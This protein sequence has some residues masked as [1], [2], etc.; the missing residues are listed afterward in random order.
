MKKDMMEPGGAAPAVAPRRRRKSAAT[1]PGPKRED[2]F[3]YPSGVAEDES[4]TAPANDGQVHEI[5]LNQIRPAPWNPPARMELAAVEE[6]A[7]NIARHGQ[8]VPALVRPVEAEAPIVFE[9]VFGHRRYAAISR[10]APPEGEGTIKTFVRPL[11]EE[12]A[13]ILSGIENL[14]RKGFSDI[15]EAEFFRTCGE[16]YG[17]H[18][19]KM[20]AEKLSVSA[21]YVRKR[22]KI[23]E[24]PERALNLWRNGTWHVGHM[25]QLLRIGDRSEVEEWLKQRADIW[26]GDRLENLQVFVLKSCIDQRAILLSHAKFNKSDC[27]ICRKNTAVQKTLFGAEGDKTCC[28]DQK[29][30]CQKQQAWLD[31]HWADGSCKANKECTKMGVIGDFA[32]PKTA[33]FGW[34]DRGAPVNPGQRCSGCQRYGTILN[35]KIEPLIE[36]VCFGDKACF[37]GLKRGY[38]TDDAT[39]AKGLTREGGA[40]GVRV[41]WHGEHFRQEFYKQEI[42]GLLEAACG[43]ND[44]PIH[45]ALAACLYEHWRLLFEIDASAW[46]F[47][48]NTANNPTLKK[49]L[50]WSCRFDRRH[51]G[52]LLAKAVISVAFRRHRYADE[53]NDDDRAA[54]A[55]FLGVDFGKW[56]PTD[57]WFEKKTKG[58]LVSY[59]ARE[60]GLAQ[61][62]KFQDYLARYHLTLE[63]LAGLKK[64][65][66]VQILHD[67][68]C[69][70]RGR[71]PDEIRSGLRG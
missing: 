16:R 35:Y 42:P 54:I 15:E 55:E 63:K 64:G 62:A 40:D 59:I 58:E 46:D 65:V 71:L 70:L 51:A 38:R 32:T 7:A 23:L 56:A 49:L 11:S 5:P 13:M 57:E 44:K 34:Q 47:L 1:A 3:G 33:G 61:D 21:T 20:L 41:K 27:K 17:D 39:E 66:I 12:D 37:D 30:F 48:A 9:L 68:G 24:L 22:I 4:L 29:C 60:S 14:Q 19:V 67:C 31:L 43:L 50:K 26:T 10:L 52:A 6:L 28:L 8:Q 25:E 69:D 18:A 53:F 45:V 36:R 2:Q